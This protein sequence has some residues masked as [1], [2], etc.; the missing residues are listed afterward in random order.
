VGVLLVVLRGHFPST[1]EQG[2]TPVLLA[3]LPSCRAVV[4][5]VGNW[6]WCTIAVFSCAASCGSGSRPAPDGRCAVALEEVLLVR[7]AECEAAAAAAPRQAGL[8]GGGGGPDEGDEEE[9]QLG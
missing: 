9:E 2:L 5:A 4:N 3:M 8:S 7:E 1:A 6:D